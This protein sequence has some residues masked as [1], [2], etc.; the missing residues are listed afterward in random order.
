MKVL[1]SIYQQ[2]WKTQH[3]PPDWKRSDIIPIPNKGNAKECGNYRTLHSWHHAIKVMF[4]ILQARLQLYVNHELSC[5]QAGF[6][7]IK[8]TRDQIASNLLDHQK[9]KRVPENH[10]LL[11]YWL[12]QNLW[13]CGSQQIV[14]FLK[15][16]EYQ[17]ILPAK[18]RAT[19]LR[20]CL[21]LFSP[22]C[23][24]DAMDW[25]YPWT[26]Q[27]VVAE[28]ELKGLLKGNYLLLAIKTG[29]AQW[30]SGKESICNAGDIGSIPGPGS[31]LGGEQ[32]NPV[33]NSFLENPTVRG[34]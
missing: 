28:E 29:F 17:T 10:L 2:I 32:G 13:L 7:K 31:C 8:G 11:L 33:R 12:C 18:Y 19:Q 25:L 23:L 22:F 15:R 27:Y 1:H 21:K 24:K 9:S 4:K 26:E 30:F 20:I 3:W 6:R 34:A 14:K 16:W 5:V